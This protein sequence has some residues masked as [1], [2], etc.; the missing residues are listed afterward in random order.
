MRAKLEAVINLSAIEGGIEL[1]EKTITANTNKINLKRKQI[2]KTFHTRSLRNNYSS[3]KPE[4][5]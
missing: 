5:S 1:Q 4:Y 3:K 2:R